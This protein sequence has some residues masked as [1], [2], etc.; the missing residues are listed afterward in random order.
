MSP[1][2]K[3]RTENPG[4]RLSGG[5]IAKKDAERPH[6][7]RGAFGMRPDTARHGQKIRPGVDQRARVIDRDPADRDAGQFEHALPP[8][9]NLGIGVM[10]DHL[11]R[12][13]IKGAESAIEV[14]RASCGERVW[15]S[16]WNSVG[17]V[18][19]KK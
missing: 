7:R 13:R 10:L 8:Y 4:A 16:V 5:L 17:S 15:Q 12:R 9:E 6:R 11:G 3:R 18:S 14:G 1:C 2:W 19:I